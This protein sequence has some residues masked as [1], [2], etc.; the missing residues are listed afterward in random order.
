M[1]SSAGEAGVGAAGQGGVGRHTTIDVAGGH[2]NVYL[3]CGND[4]VNLL[5]VDGIHPTGKQREAKASQF[6]SQR[7]Q[8]A[9]VLKKVAVICVGDTY[10]NWA[11]NWLVAF[12]VR[13]DVA[14]LSRR[15]RKKGYI[16]AIDWQAT[17][18]DILHMLRRSEVHAFAFIGHSAFEGALAPYGGSS[19][20]E[21]GFVGSFD[22]AGALGTRRLEL[23]V[24]Y[25][26]YSDRPELKEA[27]VG[28]T[29]QFEGVKGQWNPVLGLDL[30]N[31]SLK[32]KWRRKHQNGGW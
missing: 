20:D 5:D 15:F 32:G 29:G 17:K 27:L 21:T 8:K 19:N 9:V 11:T 25:S 24:V 4:P 6:A 7:V 18:E 2:P 22:I 23:A 26:C 28:N 13:R 12:G 14:Y 10:V 3:Y 31:F 1:V 30:G 16:V